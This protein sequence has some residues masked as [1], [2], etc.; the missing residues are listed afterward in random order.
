MLF[1]GMLTV[2][3]VRKGHETQA[4]DIGSIGISIV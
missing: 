2:D 3:E 4:L 1:G